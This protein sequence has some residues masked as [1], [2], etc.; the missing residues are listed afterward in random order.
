MHVHMHAYMIWF[1]KGFPN[2]ASGSLG[3]DGRPRGDILDVDSRP[4]ALDFTLS[5]LGH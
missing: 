3:H 2:N 4:R 5:P 1:R